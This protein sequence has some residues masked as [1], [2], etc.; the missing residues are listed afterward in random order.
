MTGTITKSLVALTAA[1]LMSRG[2][3]VVS[4]NMS[5]RAA[6]RVLSRNQISG[7][8]VVDEAGRCVG[9]LSTTDFM[10]RLGHV[11]HLF[12]AGPPKV[13]RICEWELAVEALPADPVRNC[14]TADPVTAGR[15]TSVSELARMMIDAHI[16][17]VV[18]VDEAYRPIGIVSSTDILAAVARETA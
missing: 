13:G 8:P 5:L 12:E 4:H 9:V 17:R 10:R 1:D 3:T 7:A 15:S 6:A 2:L 14:M 11:D 18:V 16:H